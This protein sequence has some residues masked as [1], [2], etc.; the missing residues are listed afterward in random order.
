M[1]TSATQLC[2]PLCGAAL[3]PAALPAKP[4]PVYGY[5]DCLRRC[6]ACGVGYSNGR[7]NPTIVYR[8]PFDSV[9]RE[10]RNGV[11]ST[12]AQSLNESNRATKR[13]RFGFS[14]SEDAVTWVVFSFLA[15][16][17][18]LALSGLGQRLFGFPNAGTPT[19]L[20][21]GVP[22]P[23]D[24]R[25]DSL[26]ARLVAVLDAIGEGRKGRSEPDVI[27]DYGSNGLAFIEVKLHAA[28]SV[29]SGADVGKFTRYVKNTPAFVDPVTVKNSR[30]Y[31][32][33]RNWRIGWD[34]ASSHSFR[35][36]NLG[37]PRLFERSPG[38]EL[39]ETG[40]AIAPARRF[41]RVSWDSLLE[42][43]AMDVAGIPG[44]L[45]DWLSRRGLNAAGLER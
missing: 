17:A 7:A 34:L 43:V 39:F 10:V 38:L 27:L 8:N 42:S 35:L 25:G 2:C 14:T 33:A 18:P 3:H 29:V 36:V 21:W 40:L 1:T 9:P 22:V 45:K 13:L 4:S 41:L 30:M 31:E 11:D 26:R 6:D 20:L 23:P 37:F 5:E 15:R 44:W 19:M 32:L 28:N 16:H 24:D 12:V